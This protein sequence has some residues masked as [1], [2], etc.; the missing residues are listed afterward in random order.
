MAE[1]C[2]KG[3][4]ETA[5][6][7]VNLALIGYGI[8]ARTVLVPHFIQQ[9]NVVIKAVCDCDKVRCKAGAKHVNDYYKKNKLV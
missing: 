7:T 4:A 9:S 6:K 1:K 2:K 5:A 3:V 8:Q